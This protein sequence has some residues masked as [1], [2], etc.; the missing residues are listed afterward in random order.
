MPSSVSDFGTETWLGVLLGINPP[1][2]GYWVALCSDEPGLGAD[3]TIL[4]ELE[5]TNP[6]YARQYYPAG[7]LSWGL[8]GASVTNLDEIDF[9][10][11][12]ADWGP[13]GFY[14]LC[15]SATDGEFYAV[16]EFANPQVVTAGYAMVIP[17][18]GIV[19]S[20]ASQ[21]DSITL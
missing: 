18:G 19:L 16:G 11:P 21:D 12:S 5:P 17:P 9:G 13:V 7:E 4:V 3:G 14:A 10:T 15:D 20:L 8:N 2:A 6:D 1:I